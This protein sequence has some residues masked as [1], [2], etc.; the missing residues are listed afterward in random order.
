MLE[1]LDF[2]GNDQINYTEFLSA[3]VRITPENSTIEREEALFRM[4]GIENKDY[5]DREQIK[6]AFNKMGKIITN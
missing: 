1:Q 4:F 5:I 3:T 6:K 2:D